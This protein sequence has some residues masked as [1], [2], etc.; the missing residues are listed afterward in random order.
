MSDIGKTNIVLYALFTNFE[1]MIASR[2]SK[3][4]F[5]F[6]KGTKLENRAKLKK[7]ME[8]IF[9]REGRELKSLN[10]I[11]CSDD[12]L[13]SINRDYLKHDYFTD[14]VTFELSEAKEPIDGEIYIS[15]D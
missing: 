4:Y 8:G 14:I 9:R 3:I 2:K 7:F 15:V 12:Y 11:F 6:E 5:F 1:I 13:R 10:I